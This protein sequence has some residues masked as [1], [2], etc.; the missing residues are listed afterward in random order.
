[1]QTRSPGYGIAKASPPP[2]APAEAEAGPPTLAVAL[3][4]LP[5]CRTHSGSGQYSTDCALRDGLFAAPAADAGGE[6]EK[7]Q[8]P[9][10]RAA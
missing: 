6:E 9:A 5:H 3:D 4:L 7:E 10:R 8:E 1:M 2:L